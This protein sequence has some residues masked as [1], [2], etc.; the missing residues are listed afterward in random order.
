MGVVL[1]LHR[2]LLQEGDC[3]YKANQ[4]DTIIQP[5]FIASNTNAMLEIPSF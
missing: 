3:R 5:S 2:T 4:V 1:R